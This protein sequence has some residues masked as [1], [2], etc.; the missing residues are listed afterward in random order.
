MRP[1]LNKLEFL[2]QVS[3]ARHYTN[4]MLPFRRDWKKIGEM[5]YL[6]ELWEKK[7]FDILP[8]FAKYKLYSLLSENV[9]G[10]Q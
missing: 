4:R 10:H 3:G 5:P 2:T 6:Q 7:Q 8:I 9:T 1:S